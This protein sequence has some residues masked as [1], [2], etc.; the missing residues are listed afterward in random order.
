MRQQSAVHL[1][2]PESSGAA[3]QDWS[4]GPSGAAAHWSGAVAHWS[5]AAHWS[6]GAARWSSGAAHWSSGAS[7]EEA[8]PHTLFHR[9]AVQ[10]EAP[11]DHDVESSF[12]HQDSRQD[13]AGL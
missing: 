13:A 3:A 9:A 4:R 7:Q 8:P 5:P 11:H 10:E 2:R 6:S 1:Q 12:S